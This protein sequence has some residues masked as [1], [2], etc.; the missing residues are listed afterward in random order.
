MTRR[1]LFAIAL[2]I[3]MTAFAAQDADAWGAF[4]RGYTH[5]GPRGAYH[6]GVNRVATPYGVR[7][8]ETVRGVG[9]GGYHVGYAYGAAYRPPVGPVYGGYRP[10]PVPGPVAI[11]AYR[12]G[13]Y[14]VP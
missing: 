8:T 2:S 9:P 11:P 13:V 3:T 12:P 4:H 5:V 6:V 14:R 1:F 7:T 10:I